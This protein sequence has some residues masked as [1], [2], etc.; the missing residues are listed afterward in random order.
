MIGKCSICKMTE[1][2]LLGR[3][4]DGITRCCWCCQHEG[5]IYDKVKGRCL[6]AVKRRSE[7]C[8]FCITY[9]H[10]VDL[11]LKRQRVAQRVSGGLQLVDRTRRMARLR[12]QS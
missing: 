11:L 5:H 6:K 4:Q 8:L 3:C 2:S 10:K 7:T 1:P 9:T 12:W